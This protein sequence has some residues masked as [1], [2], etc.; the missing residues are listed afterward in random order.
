MNTLFEFK[1]KKFYLVFLSVSISSFFAPIKFLIAIHIDSIGLNSSTWWKKIIILI[2]Y[3]S[4][5]KKS[6]N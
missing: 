1:N 6:Y 5:I 2:K 3:L 4:K